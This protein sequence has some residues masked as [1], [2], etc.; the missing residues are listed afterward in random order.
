MQREL[1]VRVSPSCQCQAAPL[2]A[3]VDEKSYCEERGGI[4]LKFGSAILATLLVLLAGASRTF[5]QQNCQ[6]FQALY[7]QTLMVNLSTGAGD[8]IQDLD[9]IRGVLGG[10]PVSPSVKYIPG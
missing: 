7:H 6:N 4:M 9:P 8:W 3:R 1:L 2:T 5:A 10:K